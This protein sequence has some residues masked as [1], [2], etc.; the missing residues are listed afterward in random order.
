MKSRTEFIV[1]SVMG[2]FEIRLIRKEE[3]WRV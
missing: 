1:E 3:P 2:P